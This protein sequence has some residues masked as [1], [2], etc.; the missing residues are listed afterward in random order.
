MNISRAEK[1]PLNLT[2]HTNITIFLRGRFAITGREWRCS[3]PTTASG[4]AL[5]RFY[6]PILTHA[7]EKL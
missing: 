2:T 7:L 3:R 5:S 1:L 6:E 4:F